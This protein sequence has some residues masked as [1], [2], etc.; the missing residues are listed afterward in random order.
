[1][2]KDDALAKET[3]VSAAA[4]ELVTREVIRRETRS[5]SLWNVPSEGQCERHWVALHLFRNDASEKEMG[6]GAAA[7]E[8]VMRGVVRRKLAVAPSGMF[9][10]RGQGERH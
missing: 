4:W 6:V 2:F 5:R 7:R 10:Q 1:M 8:L 3:E 9:R